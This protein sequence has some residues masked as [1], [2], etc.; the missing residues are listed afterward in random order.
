MF[1]LYLGPSAIISMQFISVT[2]RGCSASQLQAN[3]TI[4]MPTTVDTIL[5]EL[6]VE[7]SRSKG[8]DPTETKSKIEYRTSSVILTA[9]NENIKGHPNSPIDWF[10]ALFRFDDAGA[11]WIIACPYVP[12]YVEKYLHWCN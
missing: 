6:G 8:P 2:I 10:S 3:T 4:A 7:N 1:F 11:Q 12:K 9:V 5:F